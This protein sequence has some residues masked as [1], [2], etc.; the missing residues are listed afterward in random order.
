MGDDNGKD[1]LAICNSVK[2]RWVSKHDS[3][4]KDER[5][6]G[7]GGGGDGDDFDND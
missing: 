1:E 3:S 7:E 6:E 5:E 4:A 2:M